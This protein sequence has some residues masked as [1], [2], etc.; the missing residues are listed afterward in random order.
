MKNY[1]LFQTEKEVN[2]VSAFIPKKYG[3]VAPLSI[4]I[5]ESQRFGKWAE[6]HEMVIFPELGK[7][8]DEYY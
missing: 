5:E 2:D 7:N 8:S 1:K 3:K 4:A 6:D